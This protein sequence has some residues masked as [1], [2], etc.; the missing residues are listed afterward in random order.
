M[1]CSGTTIG[2]A[3]MSNHLLTIEGEYDG[4]RIK[5]LTAIKTKKKQRVLITF[6]DEPEQLKRSTRSKAK[7]SA[8]PSEL[9][10]ELQS[11][12]H[13]AGVND[14]KT[15]VVNILEEKVKAAKHKD[16]VYAVTDEIREG[17]AHAGLSE[18]EMLEDFNR[19]RRTLPRE[20][21]A[22]HD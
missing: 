12:A 14:V 6:L 5:P 9:L 8:I 1:K 4:K 15:F 3:V 19:F 2:V 7:A 13:A 18:E 22:A 16:F 20:Q 21:T 11:L 10:K 17:L